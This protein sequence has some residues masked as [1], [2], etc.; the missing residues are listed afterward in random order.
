MYF[1][2]L[3]N[4]CD[5][6]EC[7]K[8]GRCCGIGLKEWLLELTKKDVAKLRELGFEKA[9]RRIGNRNF[10]KRKRDG[11]CIFLDDDNLCYLRKRFNWYPFGC[12]LFPF[13]YRIINATLILTVN[14]EYIKRIKCKGFGRGETLGSQVDKVLDILRDEGIIEEYYVNI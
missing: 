11:S 6:F 13:G 14:T 10:L 1:I 12:R 5:R 2:P 4:P 3:F 9:I 7:V 8:C